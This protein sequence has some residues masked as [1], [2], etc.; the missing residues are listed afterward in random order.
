MD[1]C[2]GKARY[3]MEFEAIVAAA[4]CQALWGEE[5]EP[6]RHGNHYHIAHTDRALRNKHP[7]KLYCE[8]CKAE[9]RPRRWKTH[10]LLEGHARNV[11]KRKEPI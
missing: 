2:K 3:D 8:D 6:Y 11:R 1:K 5:M 7:S 4:K 9:M 10:V